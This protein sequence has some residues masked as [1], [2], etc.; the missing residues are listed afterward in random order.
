MRSGFKIAD[1]RLQPIPDQGQALGFKSHPGFASHIEQ[2]Y[3]HLLP[4]LDRL[5]TGRDLIRDDADIDDIAKRINAIRI[6][7]ATIVEDENGTFTKVSI[8][9]LR[10][11]ILTH[12]G[13]ITQGPQ[14]PQPINAAVKSA[15]TNSFG[16]PSGRVICSTR[17]ALCGGD[18]WLENSPRVC[19][20][21]IPTKKYP[22]NVGSA[23]LEQKMTITFALPAQ[24]N[25]N[26]AAS[27]AQVSGTSELDPDSGGESLL[28]KITG[29]PT[30]GRPLS[31]PH[32]LC[33]HVPDL[34]TPLED[35]HRR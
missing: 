17:R 25:F 1:S 4:V 12:D 2:G 13:S 8:R 30:P 20:S 6:N 19:A 7:H 31:C 33:D 3:L 22:H 26:L 14:G 27:T 32:P 9:Q 35:H 24:K 29:P 28:P 18:C 23:P 10:T 16:L 5:V 11:F 21:T 15:L 34:E